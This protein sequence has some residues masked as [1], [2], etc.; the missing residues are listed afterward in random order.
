MEDS[1]PALE[2]KFAVLGKGMR[3]Y[4]FLSMIIAIVKTKYMPEKAASNEKQFVDRSVSACY[5][6]ISRNGNPT[7]DKPATGSKRALGVSCHVF[8]GAR[9]M[10]VNQFIRFDRTPRTRIGRYLPFPVSRPWG[11]LECKGPVQMT[12]V[13]VFPVGLAC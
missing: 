13:Y 12:P 6:I 4:C 3:E 11:R 9:F 8:A 5:S 1:L 2:Q 10:M 7:S